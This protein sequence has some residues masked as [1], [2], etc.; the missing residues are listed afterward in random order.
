MRDIRIGGLLHDVGK[1]GVPDE[2]LRKPGRLTDEEYEVMKQH[3]HLG[4]LI[5]GALPGMESVLDAVRSH[6]ERWDGKGYPDATAGEDTP[7]LGRILAVADAFSA[8][9][10]TR[11]YRKGMDWETALGQIG[12]N[13]GTQFDPAMAAAFLT[14]AQKRHAHD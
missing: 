11:P 7:L 13:V 6:H 4:S 3:T 14:A 1:I 10:T 5:V 2:I 9:T 8:M 12:A